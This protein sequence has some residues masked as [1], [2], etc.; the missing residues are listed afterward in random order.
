MQL[1]SLHTRTLHAQSA[2]IF[3][4]PIIKVVLW[5]DSCPTNEDSVLVHLCTF[6]SSLS[7]FWHIFW[8]HRLMRSFFLL[9]I[10]IR[11]IDNRLIR[12]ICNSKNGWQ[13][14]TSGKFLKVRSQIG[15]MF[16]NYGTT[17]GQLVK[18]ESVHKVA[19]NS[20]QKVSLFNLS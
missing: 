7:L 13:W 2:Q 15:E 5:S 9:I 14:L 1:C 11:I 20:F 6:V 8:E 12:R 17:Q 16:C 10:D 19:T 4:C 3:I 18:S